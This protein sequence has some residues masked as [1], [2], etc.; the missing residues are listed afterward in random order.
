[1]RKYWKAY[2]PLEASKQSLHFKITKKSLAEKASLDST[3]TKTECKR[4][5]FCGEIS[6]EIGKTCKITRFPEEERSSN[7]PKCESP[8]G[9]NDPK[10][11]MF[12]AGFRLTS[13]AKKMKE[14]STNRSTKSFHGYSAKNVKEK[15]PGS[16][17]FD[18]SIGVGSPNTLR[19]VCSNDSGSGQQ[20]DSA[21]S[22]RRRS[23]ARDTMRRNGMMS[24]IFL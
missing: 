5:L 21:N 20:H 3:E 1:M 12:A 2:T 16:K 22:V 6:N 15:A 13:L 8:L 4:Q 11:V 9:K 10:H 23:V 14:I 7:W 19:K 18:T 17:S 24:L